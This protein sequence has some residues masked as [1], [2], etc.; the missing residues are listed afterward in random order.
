VSSRTARATQRNP[1]SKNQNQ[2]NKKK[3]KKKRSVCNQEFLVKSFKV[4]W[5][6]EAEAG[7]FL[8]LRSACS[9]KGFPG[10]PGLHRETLSQKQTNKQT[11]VSKARE[12]AQSL[13]TLTALSRGPEFNI[14]QPHGGYNHM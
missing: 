11:K 6:V 9:T 10:H 14:Q 12:T 4:S 1:V 8:S 7:G 2:T 3:K 13:K 5:A